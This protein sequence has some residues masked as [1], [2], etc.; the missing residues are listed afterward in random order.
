M[1]ETPDFDPTLASKTLMREGR[2][3]AL[4]SLMPG[5]GDP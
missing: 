3:A 5:A 4:A 1:K 2:T